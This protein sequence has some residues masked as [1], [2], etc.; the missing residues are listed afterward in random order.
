MSGK[1]LGSLGGQKVPNTSEGY[2]P[3]YLENRTVIGKAR[4]KD[5]MVEMEID[6]ETVLELMGSNLI[7]LSTISMGAMPEPFKEEITTKE[8]TDE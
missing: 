8:K 4:I 3:L 6:D 1:C 2:I 5:N 7:G